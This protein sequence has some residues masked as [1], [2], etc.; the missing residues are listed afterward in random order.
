MKILYLAHR[1]PYPPDKGDKLRA[2]RQIEHLSKHHDVTLACFVDDQADRVH[3]DKLREYCIEVVAIDL[4]Q[5]IA[6]VRGLWGLLRGGTVTEAYYRHPEMMREISRLSRGRRFDA[7]VGFSSGM[8]PYLIRT[9]VRHR[10]MDYCDCDSQKWLAYA[11]AASFPMRHVYQTEGKRLSKKERA[12]ASTFDATILITDAEARSLR[13][14]VAKDRLHV[15]GNGVPLPSRDQAVTEAHPPTVGFVGVMDYRP[16]VDAV[17][18]F[19]ERCW[20]G[21]REAVPDATFLIVGRSPN[22]SVQKLANVAGVEVTGGVSNIGPVMER[23]DVSV[24]PMRI[25]RGLQNKVLEAMAAAKP[26]VMTPIAEEGLCGRNGQE[27]LVSGSEEALIRDV[28]R[29]LH[30]PNERR[31]IGDAARVHVAKHHCW[32]DALERFEMIVTGEVR[33]SAPIASLVLERSQPRAVNGAMG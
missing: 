15:V 13:N 26:V 32:D 3:I 30:D 1:I 22:A 20:S 21:I 18:W 7:A 28:R 23:I 10:V 25:A 16:N 11:K 24:A 4:N 9:H 29:L 33:R 8:A 17:S 31:R 5:R 14:Y 12:W 27:Y 2:F 19:V 6:K